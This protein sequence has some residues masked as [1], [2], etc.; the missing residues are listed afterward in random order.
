MSVNF[1]KYGLT[2]HG[3]APKP[4]QVEWLTRE[5]TAF[6]HFGMNT[7]TNQEW[8]DGTED[9]TTFNPP[10]DLDVRSWVRSVKDAGFRAALLTAKHHDGFC[11]WP[12]KTTEHSIKNSPYKSGKGDIVRD[13]M[14]ACREYGLRAGLY[15]SPWDRHEPCWGEEEYN[16]FYTRQLTELLTW[17]GQV[18]EM[19]W[20]GAGSHEAHYDWGRWSYVVRNLQPECI[21]YGPPA[22]VP[23]IDTRW[24]GNE[25]GFAGDPCWATMHAYPGCP[26]LRDHLNNGHA[27]GEYFLPAEV[28]VSIRPGWFYHTSQDDEVKPVS[29]LLT[30]WFDSVGRNTGLVMNIPPMPNGRL[31]PT[32]VANYRQA[33]RLLKGIFH[34]NLLTGAHVTATSARH[35]DCV[36]EMLLVEDADKFYAAAEGDNTPTITLN[37]PAEETINCLRIA[38]MIQLGHRVRGWAVDAFVDGEWKTV[39]EGQ[40]IGYL[41][42]PRFPAVTT[43]RVRLRITAADCPPVLREFG[44]Y[45]I[46]EE[47]FAEEAAL[48]KQVNLAANASAV[49]TRDGKETVINLGG[50]YDYNTVVFDSRNSFS[51]EI[52][53][54]NGSTWDK[55]KRGRPGSRELVKF[56]TV[57]GSYQLKIVMGDGFMEGDINPEVYCQEG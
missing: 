51:Y 22:V 16:N 19:W 9:P 6:F 35:A 14:D 8:G 47:V 40:C 27:D 41:W 13:F 5:M 49:I 17:Y 54:F 46:G 12:T 1:E 21:L 52:W 55:V 48:R 37:L 53:A 42:A 45:H 11:L 20:D 32:D 39:A 28:D 26:E 4:R 56:D 18:D 44:A 50:V 29:R 30:C 33:H 23:C 15:L 25:G 36:P 2:P 7:Y 10:E 34:Y 3:P 38:E 57:R 31:H 24:V 43:S